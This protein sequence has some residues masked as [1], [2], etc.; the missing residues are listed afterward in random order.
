MFIIGKNIT[1]RA[2]DFKKI[3]RKRIGCTHEDLDYFF[4][5]CY[6]I[7]VENLTNGLYDEVYVP[8]FGIYELVYKPPRIIK[9]PVYRG[10]QSKFPIMAKE[11]WEL[12]IRNQ[13]LKNRVNKIYTNT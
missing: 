1:L 5:T 10:K 9:R 13:K 3:C 2:K 7:L 4:E 8:Y 11:K 12:E 6:E